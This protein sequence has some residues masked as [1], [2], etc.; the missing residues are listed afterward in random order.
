MFKRILYENWHSL[1][2]LI[3]FVLTF[4]VFI[5]AFVRTLLMKKDQVKHMATLPLDLD[6]TSSEEIHPR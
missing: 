1:V 5:V 4:A 6:E 3:A 2:P